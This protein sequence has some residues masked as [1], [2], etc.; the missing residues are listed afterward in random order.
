VLANQRRVVIV[1]LNLDLC[2]AR[3]A[4]RHRRPSA[5]PRHR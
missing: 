5:P 1:D 4:R 3:A 2:A